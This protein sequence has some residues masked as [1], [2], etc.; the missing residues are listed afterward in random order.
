MTIFNAD[1][2]NDTDLPNANEKP[3]LQSH[4]HFEFGTFG[5]RIEHACALFESSPPELTHEAGEPILT[6]SLLAWAHEQGICMNWLLGGDPSEIIK[7]DAKVRKAD[8][9]IFEGY[10]K[11]VPE[12]QRAFVAYLRAVVIHG[13]PMKEAEPLFAQVLEEFRVGNAELQAPA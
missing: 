3:A 6:D 1:S 10:Q 7:R 8:R 13:I 4:R 11:F 12:V 2:A 9:E 5:E